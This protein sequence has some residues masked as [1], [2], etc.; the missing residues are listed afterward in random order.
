M[1]RAA[2]VFEAAAVCEPDLP[3]EAGHEW[4]V[5]L[6]PVRATNVVRRIH[7]AIKGKEAAV[8]TGLPLGDRGSFRQLLT[9]LR[10]TG[11][12]TEL[13]QLSEALAEDGYFPVLIS[14]VREV[15]L[16]QLTSIELLMAFVWTLHDVP[17]VADF[18]SDYQPAPWRS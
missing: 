9:G 15:N 1:P 12:T 8:A 16:E 10:G 14:G 11:K 13:N 3:L 2:N 18:A 5:D 17:A 7:R 6:S 4:Y